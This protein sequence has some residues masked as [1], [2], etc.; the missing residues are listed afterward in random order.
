M[1]FAG[2]RL[3]RFGTT[4][5]AIETIQKRFAVVPGLFVGWSIGSAIGRINDDGIFVLGPLG[6]VLSDAMKMAVR[7][8][9]NRGA[10]RA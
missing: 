8:G 7:E 1:S 10:E 4:D 9:R 2:P 6:D 5:S 3:Y